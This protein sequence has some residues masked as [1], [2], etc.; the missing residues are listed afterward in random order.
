MRVSNKYINRD[1]RIDSMKKYAKVCPNCGS[2]NIGLWATDAGTW[3]FCKDCE[4]GKAV[5]MFG[6]SF[7]EVEASELEKFRE[8]L[9]KSR[10]KK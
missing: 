2:A 3:N 4:F 8:E 9:R 10:K 1:M 5:S 6:G 7:P